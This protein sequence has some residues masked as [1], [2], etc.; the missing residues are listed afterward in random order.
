MKE[1]RCHLQ[2]CDGAAFVYEHKNAGAGLL[3]HVRD[4]GTDTA[5]SSSRRERRAVHLGC[6]SNSTRRVPDTTVVWCQK[7]EGGHLIVC[8]ALGKDALA[9][10]NKEI[11]SAVVQDPVGPRRLESKEG[12]VEEHAV[13]RKELPSQL[14][15][16][17]QLDDEATGQGAEGVPHRVQLLAQAHLERGEQ[18][19]VHR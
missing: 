9:G 14:A 10:S 12:V 2:L 16:L 11:V 7:L 15:E 1:W 4:A 18:P 8:G 19:P 6:G 3:L 17:A 5:S 13:A